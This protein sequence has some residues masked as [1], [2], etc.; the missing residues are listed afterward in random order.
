VRSFTEE[1]YG[2]HNMLLDNPTN[3]DFI[4]LVLVSLGRF[5]QQNGNSSF[6]NAFTKIIHI[7][8]EHGVF[9]KVS[10]VVLQIALS[11]VTNLGTRESRLNQLVESISFLATEMLVK[12]PSLA[13]DALGE[14]F[15]GDISIMKDAPSIRAL[16]QTI[17]FDNFNEVSILL[18]V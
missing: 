8:I 4:E 14:N 17:M 6:P 1:D 18:K 16:G 11:R 9:Q 2:L 3:W 13:C 12:N 5:C 15:F 7:L 10:S